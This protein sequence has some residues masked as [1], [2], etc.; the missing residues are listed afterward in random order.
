MLN[1]TGSECDENNLIKL[2]AQSETVGQQKFILLST[3]Q[4]DSYCRGQAPNMQNSPR[5]EN[6]YKYSSHYE[7]EREFC[8]GITF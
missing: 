5:I 1:L 7:Y 3:I 6:N 8:L 4:T 2:L